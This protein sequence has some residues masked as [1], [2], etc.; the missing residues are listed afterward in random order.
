[1]NATQNQLD[2]QILN[3]LCR[4]W[5][6]KA[7]GHTA[8]RPTDAY[9]AVALAIDGPGFVEDGLINHGPVALGFAAGLD[10]GLEIAA[11]VV[12]DPLGNPTPAI[13]KALDEVTR[14]LRDI[15]AEQSRADELKAQRSK[16]RRSKSNAADTATE[17]S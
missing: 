12:G 16:K 10:F 4:D 6:A 17:A 9:E 15:H 14:R 7:T 1:M 3:A 8:D 11:A 2:A 13:R 5:T